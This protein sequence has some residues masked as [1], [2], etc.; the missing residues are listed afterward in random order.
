VEDLV[1]A[2]CRHGG[3]ALAALEGARPDREDL[4]VGA[5]AVDEAQCETVK[6]NYNHRVGERGE[7]GDGL[8]G[9]RGPPVAV[10][11]HVLDEAEPEVALGPFGSRLGLGGGGVGAGREQRGEAGREGGQASG[12]EALPLGGRCARGAG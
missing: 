1:R 4:V 12:H 9:E 11:L 6:A 10:V 8:A 5:G 2:A 3:Q 7:A